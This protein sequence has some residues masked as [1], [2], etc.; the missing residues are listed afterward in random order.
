MA[1]LTGEPSHQIVAQALTALRNLEHRGASGSEPESGDGA[2]TLIQVPDQF[3]R[4]VVDFALPEIG[5]YAVG[6]AFLPTNAAAAQAVKDRV[7]TIA[8]EEGLQVL[9]WRTVPTNPAGLG[10][11]ALQVMPAFA[12]LFVAGVGN[13]D[14]L[15]LDRLAFCLRKRVE[16]ELGLYFSS[17][18][19][20]TIVY[21]GMLTTAQL[22]PFYPD[23]S[24]DRVASAM[25]LATRSS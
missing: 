12:Q 18:S 5:R 1:T 24:D 20:R 23:L 6:M 16:H 11:T 19:C 8:S 7:G 21:K 25:A 4:E 3:L 22:E 15:A 14:D 13:E 2:G 17:L 10:R 9:G